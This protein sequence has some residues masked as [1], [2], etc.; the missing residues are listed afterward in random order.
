MPCLYD[1]GKRSWFMPLERKPSA[2]NAPL[3]VVPINGPLP[4][5]IP[6]QVA[7]M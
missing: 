1:P 6:I 2:E 3:R 7:L 5:D 4:G